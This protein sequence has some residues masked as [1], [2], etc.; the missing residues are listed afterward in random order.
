MIPN[1]WRGF[2]FA[3]GEDVDALRDTVAR[4]SQRPD[5]AARRRDRP[6]EHVSARSV[7]AAR[8]TRRA[9]HHGRGGIR[10]R[11][12]GLSRPLRRDGRNLARLGV[13]R[14]VLRRAFESVRQ[15]DPPQRH[16][17]AEAPLSAEARLRR[18]CRRARDVGAELRLGCRV[19]AHARR[20]E[21][22]PLHPQRLEDVDHQR[23][24][25]RDLRGLRQDRPDRRLA[26]HDGVHR[27]EGLQGIFPGAEARQAR[28]ARLRHRANSCSRI[29][30]CRRKTCSARSATAST[31]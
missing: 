26:R 31:C 16:G 18:A 13:G 9:R 29:A 11:G 10:R 19:D 17:R 15:P 7:A 23:A 5:R 2:D 21:G 3:L 20:Q 28:H 6:A 30:R 25:G 1:A 24:G 14:P 4:F 8:R 12:H 27:R 22:R